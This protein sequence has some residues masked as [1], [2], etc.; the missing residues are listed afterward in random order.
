MGWHHRSTITQFDHQPKADADRIMPKCET[1]HPSILTSMQ[2]LTLLLCGM[3]AGLSVS[4]MYRAQYEGTRCYFNMI[5]PTADSDNQPALLG[6]HP[7]RAEAVLAWS[8]EIAYGW[9]DLDDRNDDDGIQNTLHHLL[10]I[11][12]TFDFPRNAPRIVNGFPAPVDLNFVSADEATEEWRAKH[13]NY[14]VGFPYSVYYPPNPVLAERN[15]GYIMVAVSS[16]CR[17]WNVTRVLLESLLA[18][19]DPIHVV[20]MDDNS[21]VWQLALV[22]IAGTARNRSASMPI[23]VTATRTPS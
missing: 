21:K 5:M 6:G 20:L 7:R 17:G 19:D 15:T 22:D 18:M 2:E 23:I 12:D 10:T 3:V 13:S 4:A 14:H 16:C 1:T 8:P 9:M 11:S